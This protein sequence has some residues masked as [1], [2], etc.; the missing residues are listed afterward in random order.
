MKDTRSLASRLKDRIRIERPV[1]A[2]GFKGAGSGS[3]ETV[4]DDVSAEIEDVLPSRDERLSSGLNIATRR[5]RVR[6]RYRTDIKA[7]MRFVDITDG[8]DGRIMQIIGGPAKLG[9]EAVEFMVEDYSTA[10]SGA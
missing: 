7:D 3:W 2:S 10:G 4:Q 1:T 6:L 5:A 8:T 9:R